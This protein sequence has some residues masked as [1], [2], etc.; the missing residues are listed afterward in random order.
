[1]QALSPGGTVH[2][3][4]TSRRTLALALTGVVVAAAAVAVVLVLVSRGGGDG[5]GGSATTTAAAASR[6]ASVRGIPQQGIVLGNP[7]APALEEY[8]DVQCPYCGEAAL[9]LLP[10]VI[11]QYVRT[12]KVKLVWRGL[13]FLGPDSVKGLKAIDAAAAQNRLW[14]VA[15]R[16]YER[17]GQENSGWVT[18][19]LLD[20]VGASVAG[21]DVSRWKSDFESSATSKLMDEAS[22]AA[23]N[24]GVRGTPTFLLD[25]RPVP[26]SALDIAAF[27]KA[28][29]PMLG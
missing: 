12:G 13:A 10:D 16:L 21:L 14:D 20:E 17:Q 18:D 5:N 25:G 29:D 24:A 19:E 7:D 27:H 11:D 15:E 9:K 28:I 8:A 1:M 4:K 6:P 26:L 2:R 23:T 22:T 3:M